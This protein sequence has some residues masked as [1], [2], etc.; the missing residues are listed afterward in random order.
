MNKNKDFIMKRFSI[1]CV[2]I[3]GS[4][5]CHA[6]FPEIELLKKQYPI[7]VLTK[8]QMY[9]DMDSLI[10]TIRHCNPQ[11]PLYKKIAGYDMT[12]RILMYRKKIETIDSTIQFI[13]LLKYSFRAAIDE[14]CFPGVY[15]W[16]FNN[17]LYKESAERLR[18]TD[19]DYG[20]LF[21]CR[22]QIFYNNPLCLSMIPS[23][24]S[25]FLNYRTTFYNFHDTLTFSPGTKIIKINGQSPQ[26]SIKNIINH[27]SRWDKNEHTFYTSMFI[28]DSDNACITVETEQGSK[29]VRFSKIK[30]I[31]TDNNTQFV[32]SFFESDSILY[33]SL[34][35][36]N[37]DTLSVEKE[38]L[39]YR[40]KPIKS[41]IIDIRGN[42]GGSDKTWMFLLGLIGGD[43]FNYSSSLAIPNDAQ[44]K[45][46]YNMAT[47]TIIFPFL[48]SCY[49][50]LV[51][52]NAEESIFP[53]KENLNYSG[54]IYLLVDQFIFSSAGS[55]ASLNKSNNRIVT[56]GPPTGK[57]VGRGIT[58]DLFI[59][60]NSRL[61]YT[62]ELALD[63][64]NVKCAADFFHNE[65]TFLFYPSSSYYRYYYNPDRGF[66]INEEQMYKNDEIFLKALEIIKNNK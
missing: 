20:H 44:V 48:D 10:S 6:Q 65:V 41:I 15:V 37:F 25:Y 24:G 17:T 60:P 42:Y 4:L 64:A 23:Q 13:D 18:L 54:K 43:T 16:F 21:N 66:S 22:D 40:E 29:K 26:R 28:F 51:L 50:Y 11:Y 3:L 55:F 63:F 12:D 52:E 7:P 34:P 1:L 49:Q 19:E 2:I 45:K 61:F 32:S 31:E 14:H 53:A 30:Q 47:D 8:E 38:I 39:Q 56:I 46:L 35:I 58:P 9:E 36:M 33:I 57:Y 5:F 59:L 62:M 27:S